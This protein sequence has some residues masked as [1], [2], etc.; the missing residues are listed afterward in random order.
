[1]LNFK[2]IGCGAAGNKA[3][4]CL[5]KAGFDLKNITLINSTPKDIPADYRN[6]SIIF[7]VH[8]GSALGGCGKE[9][10][11]GRRL[12]IDDM[13]NGQINIDS[14]VDATTNTAI[15][16]S[17]TEGGSGSGITPLL[18]KYIHEVLNIP[19]IVVLFFGFNTDVRGMQN[20][21]E[22]CQELQNNYGVIGISNAK[23][24]DE[25][26]GNKIKAEQMANEEFCKIIRILCG[27]DIKEG[28]QNIDDTDLY[29]LVVTPGYMC[30][31]TASLK[32]VK[33]I[34]MF[35]KV[36]NMAIDESH[37]VETTTKSAKRI[38]AIFNIP[39]SMSD[40]VDYNAEVLS[41]RYGNPYEMFTH[42]Q[43]T[44]ESASVSWISAGMAL[45]IDE[46]KEIFENYKKATEKVHKSTDDFFSVIQ[47]FKGDQQDG[48]FN[49]LS[50]ARRTPT[51][52]NAAKNSFFSVYEDEPKTPAKK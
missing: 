1:M 37:L 21:I 6:N 23:Y 16:V 35:N 11:V 41:Q 48:M 15:I 45:P 33:N 24:L 9:R 26:N 14:V 50:D 17:S 28:T 38:G 29:K 42:V 46:V 43:D 52:S 51:V 44:S 19:V 30:V 4:I 34:D 31:G 8:N 7:G 5:H 20:S 13:K 3:A 47:N 18:A 27:Q 22:I 25:A 32:G 12:I 40:S 39:S 36:V 10:D 49:M 2:V